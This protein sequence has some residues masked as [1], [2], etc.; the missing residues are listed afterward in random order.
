[1]HMYVHVGL[2]AHEAIKGQ[3]KCQARESIHNRHVPE[4]H[5]CW[6]YTARFPLGVVGWV[7][8]MVGIQRASIV[9]WLCIP[10]FH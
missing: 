4:N 5:L 2:S 6:I 3:T 8:G 9:N 1:M 10:H 7:G